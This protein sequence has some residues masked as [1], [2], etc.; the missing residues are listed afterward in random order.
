M[1]RIIDQWDKRNEDPLNEYQPLYVR[2]KLYFKYMN[3][4]HKGKPANIAEF[5]KTVLEIENNISQIANKQIER[6]A[7]NSQ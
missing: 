6:S 5:R 4:G 3:E 1:K 2:F 7:K